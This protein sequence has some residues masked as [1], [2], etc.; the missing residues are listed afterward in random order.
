V[1]V[2]AGDKAGGIGSAMD[3]LDSAP[4]GRGSS[5]SRSFPA[6]CINSK[7]LLIAFLPQLSGHS[8]LDD[9][10]RIALLQSRCQDLGDVKNGSCFVRSK[11]IDGLY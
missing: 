2:R 11:V 9:V 3:G 10:T 6:R 7:F 8:L 5:I 1:D 4:T